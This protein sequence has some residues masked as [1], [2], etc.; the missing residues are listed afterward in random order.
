M[1]CVFEGT[2]CEWGESNTWVKK[3]DGRM[4]ATLTPST[5]CD[6]ALRHCAIAPI[7][8][9]GQCH[10]IAMLLLM[11]HWPVALHAEMCHDKM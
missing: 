6:I 5:K 10:A 9:D 11:S 7:S 3:K 2:S 4:A 8:D 1:R